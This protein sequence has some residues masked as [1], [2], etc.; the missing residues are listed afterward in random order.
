[1]QP[2]CS[3]SFQQQ[4]QTINR[5]QAFCLRFFTMLHLIRNHM[6]LSLKTWANN[7]MS[8]P[9]MYYEL[10]M[11]LSNSDKDLFETSTLPVTTRQSNH[12]QAL[13]QSRCAQPKT[14]DTNIAQLWEQAAS[15]YSSSAASLQYTF[16]FDPAVHMHNRA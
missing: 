8:I 10:Q 5:Y 3:M 9:K 16:N 12:N 13:E 6:I 7:E 1:M 15:T 2:H 11:N 4:A 14:T